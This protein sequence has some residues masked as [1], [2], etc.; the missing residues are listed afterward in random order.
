MIDES[1]RKL[2]PTIV[3]FEKEGLSVFNISLELSYREK[4]DFIKRVAMAREK[5]LYFNI[6]LNNKSEFFKKLRKKKYISD[7]FK[8][9]SLLKILI[10][11]R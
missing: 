4:T 1:L 6:D 7:K 5:M 11:C 9:K 10:L 3:A 2:E 8:V